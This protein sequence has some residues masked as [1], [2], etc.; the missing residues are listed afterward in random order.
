MPFVHPML[1]QARV[2]RVL[3]T[4]AVICVGGLAAGVSPALGAFPGENGRIAFMSDRTG[5][6]EEIFDMSSDGSQQRN[7]T[8]SPADDFHESYSPDGG[9]IVFSTFRDAAKARDHAELYVMD[10][11]GSNQ[12]RITF[13]GLPDKAPAWSPDGKWLVFART[14][15]SK[16]AA[17]GDLWI[18]NV[19]SGEERNV[20]NSPTVD[21]D[22]PQWSPDGTRIAF[23]SD[24]H[25][26]GNRDV[27]T[28]RPDGREL[29]RLTNTQA[30]DSDP[31]YSPDS[32]QITFTSARH[33]HDDIFVMRADGANQTRLT[34][35]PRAEFLS[36][37]SPDG[38]FIAFS[39]ERD[40]DRIPG[41]GGRLF[42][43]DIF[44]MRADGSQQTKLTTS[45]ANDDFRPDWQPLLRR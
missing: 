44:R 10:A 2:S 35:G 3:R 20:T 16:K 32:R 18:L 39:S 28:I 5:D 40:G 13:N 26:A 21:D 6:G 15:A 37:F 17:L 7:L 23:H 25:E 42:F 43:S 12:R 36:C 9:H 45:P 31:N 4:L 24:A 1:R 22:E 8:N 11:N 14:A 27:Y 34:D 19:E 38:R 30:S 33:G 29:R 41:T